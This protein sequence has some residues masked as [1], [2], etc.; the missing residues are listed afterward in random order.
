MNKAIIMTTLVLSVYYILFV[1]NAAFKRGLWANNFEE[2][3][4]PTIPAPI[5]ETSKFMLNL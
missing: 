3:A 1:N 2:V 4:S 5:I